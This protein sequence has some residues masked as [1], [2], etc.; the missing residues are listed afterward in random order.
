MPTPLSEGNQNN[1]RTLIE[2][3]TGS[4]QP[5]IIN[6][7]VLEYGMHTIIPASTS[8]LEQEA[9]PYTLNCTYC[10]GIIEDNNVDS[11]SWYRDALWCDRDIERHYPEC[12]ICHNRRDRHSITTY[13]ASN[14]ELQ[15]VCDGCIS[16]V[17]GY[18][19]DR[20]G[21]IFN[22]DDPQWQT[23]QEGAC[24]SCFE[25]SGA[26]SSE[27]RLRSFREEENL[28]LCQE[29]GNTVK[30]LRLY[31]VELEAEYPQRKN[32]VKA[33]KELPPSIGLGSD[34][35]IQGNGI[36]I[37]FCPSRGIAGENLVVNTCKTLTAN[38]FKVNPSCGFHV[39]F[40]LEDIEEMTASDQL[41]A[42][43][44]IWTAYIAFEDAITSFLPA[45]RRGNRY[46]QQIRS[47]YSIDEIMQSPNKDSLE[48]LWYRV[49]TSREVSNAKSEHSHRTRYR[50]VN[51]HPFWQ[52][53][54]MEIRFHTGTLHPQKILEWVNLNCLIIDRA[55]KSRGWDM[56]WL[57]GICNETDIDIKIEHLFR[58]TGLSES[59]RGY[60]LARQKAFKKAEKVVDSESF[61]SG[62]ILLESEKEI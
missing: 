32:A 11:F 8:S 46:C 36:E 20:C 48:R 49:R 16:T 25:S 55:L 57:K 37:R 4:A 56:E 13:H 19:C 44:Q 59:S 58:F 23:G 27:L 24:V 12:A 47:E 18:Q 26:S 51:L 41:N 61:K 28:L 6:C 31:G 45:S 2:E 10:G 9:I 34:S 3:M 62:M 22:D 33:A 60:F 54:H 14:G 35:S 15:N 42:L 39:H 52:D 30:S 29:L 50:G 5:N 53:G 38:K 7:R 43:K 1:P 17:D 40:G 21:H